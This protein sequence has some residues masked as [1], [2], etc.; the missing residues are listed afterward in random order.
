MDDDII[1]GGVGGYQLTRYPS[2]KLEFNIPNFFLFILYFIE[3][4][5][6]S[7]S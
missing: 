4:S 2:A 3:S 1:R 5:S 7:V 6:P